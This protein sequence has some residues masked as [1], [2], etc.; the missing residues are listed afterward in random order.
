[1]RAA[2]DVV[3]CP[4]V[5]VRP[6]VG[7][8]GQLIDGRVVFVNRSATAQL[9]TVVE[10]RVVSEAFADPLGAV[11]RLIAD[12]WLSPGRHQVTLHSWG[13]SM[14]LLA[15]RDGDFVVL[16]VMD[17]A[18]AQEAVQRMERSEARF[19][20]IVQH[21]QVSMT[22]LEPVLDESGAL[23]DAIVRFRNARADADR[24]GAVLVN[25]LVSAAYLSPEDF[26]PA[27]AEAWAT[28]LTVSTSI[29]NDG[30]EEMRSLQPGYIETTLARVGDLL[31]EISDDRSDE[32]SHIE[33]LERSERLYRAIADEVRQPLHI[34]RPIF[35]DD[36][37]LVDFEVVYVNHAAESARRRA[38]SIV[39]MRASQVIADWGSGDALRAA[40]RA[41]LRGGEPVDVDALVAGDDG[42]SFAVRL[43]LR[44]MGDHMV[45]FLMPAAS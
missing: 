3:H 4:V 32:R 36:D 35:D 45:S 10:G 21:L 33:D 14:Q 8:A 18:E 17:R 26:L 41:M 30:T 16:T 28:G 38:N 27:A 6:I 19:R 37:E 5:V 34:N 15:E 12:A 43:Q 13:A 2:L 23:V 9:P 31:V 20:E 25:R 7:A 40:R 11:V 39:G 1:M 29:R 22:L 42:T 44:R 24:P